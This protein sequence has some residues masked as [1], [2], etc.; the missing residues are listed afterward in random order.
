M[1]SEL[2]NY[3]QRIDDLRNQVILLIADADP[4]ALNSTPASKGAINS[5]AVIAAHIAGAEQFWISEV[6]GQHPPTRDRDAEFTTHAE[7]PSELVLLLKKTG[8]ETRNLLNSLDPSSLDDTRN[9]KHRDVPIRWGI[10][11]VID[12]TALHLGHLQITLQLNSSDAGKPSPFWH[13]RLPSGC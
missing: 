7:H 4:E 5:P 2:E 13:E 1:I 6:I 8:D 12:H 11:H 3:I 10:L 9:V